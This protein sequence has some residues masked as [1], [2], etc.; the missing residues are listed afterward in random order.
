MELGDGVFEVKSTAGNNK[1]GGDDFDQ[2]IIDYLVDEFKRENGVD[3]S[4]D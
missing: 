4:K 2:R 1:L 3:L